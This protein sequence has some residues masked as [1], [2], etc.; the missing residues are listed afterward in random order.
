M[1]LPLKGHGVVTS[2]SMVLL[3]IGGHGVVT[4]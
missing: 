2:G 1:L 3:P 4:L